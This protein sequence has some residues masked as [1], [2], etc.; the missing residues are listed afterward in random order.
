MLGLTPQEFYLHAM[1]GREELVDT[2]VKTAT[3]GY[4]QRRLVK[5]MED[6]CVKYDGTIRNAQGHIVALQYGP[7]GHDSQWLE[8]VSAPEMKMSDQQIREHYIVKESLVAD[9]A[10]VE[11]S[12][13]DVIHI[14]RQRHEIRS[15][16]TFFEKDLAASLHVPFDGRR[17]HIN[18]R[19]TMKNRREIAEPVGAK[20]IRDTVGR[21]MASTKCPL[22][23]FMI[24]TTFAVARFTPTVGNTCESLKDK[25]ATASIGVVW[26]QAR[27]SARSPPVRSGNPAPR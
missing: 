4:L 13:E 16:K 25:F 1:G 9:K 7:E 15:I 18:V 23:R 6:L 26:T 22:T 21:L 24:R 10:M 5:V 8:R 27:W 19:H 20:D 3:T 11:L 2:A 14:A 12:Q 17:C